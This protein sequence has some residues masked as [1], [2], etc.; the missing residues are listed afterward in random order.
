MKYTPILLGLWMFLVTP[1]AF[2]QSEITGSLTGLVY[3]VNGQ[4][5]RPLPGI[6]IDVYKADTRY[7]G[8]GK[9]DAKPLGRHP[10]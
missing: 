10:G 4:T 9:S 6:T 2:A 7:W 3:E 1:G 5:K 8:S